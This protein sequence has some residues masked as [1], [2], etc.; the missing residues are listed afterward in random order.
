MLR[1]IDRQLG[2]AG[3]LAVVLDA[4]DVVAKRRGNTLE[5]LLLCFADWLVEGK[6]KG[7]KKR[8]R[9]DVRIEKVDD[10]SVDETAAD[11]DVVV[12]LADCRKRA[13]ARLGD[14]AV[15]TPSK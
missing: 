8:L 5:R 7:K 14:Y 9:R 11:K 6:K 2:L 15:S 3:A 12:V 1:S 4:D 10:K 13:W